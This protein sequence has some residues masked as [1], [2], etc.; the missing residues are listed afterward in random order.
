MKMQST[1]LKS[2]FK[3]ELKTHYVALSSSHNEEYIA[4]KENS[5]KQG[6]EKNEQ[7]MEMET[8]H[9][10]VTIRCFKVMAKAQKDKDVNKR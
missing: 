10:H 4:R 5:H 2:S 6:S 1:P 8:L 7:E 9:L 3:Q